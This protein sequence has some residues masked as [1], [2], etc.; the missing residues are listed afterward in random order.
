MSVIPTEIL[1]NGSIY[2]DNNHEQSERYIIS[3]VGIPKI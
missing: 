1:M 3:A 2:L